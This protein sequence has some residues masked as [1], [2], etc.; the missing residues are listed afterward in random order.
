LVTN[1]RK[2]LFVTGTDTNVG[3]TIAS[4][5]LMH[6]Y[7][8]E[9]RLCYWKPIQTGIESDD[10]TA[11]VRMLGG[12][13]DCEML[14]RGIRLRLPLSP[15]LSARLAG[16]HINLDELVALL[17]EIPEST[18]PVVEGAGGILVPLNDHDLMVDLIARLDL[19]AVIVARS[20]LGTINHT[21]LSLESLR[22]GEIKIGGVIMIGEPNAENRAAIER[23]GKVPVLGELPVLDLLNPETLSQWAANELDPDGLLMEYLV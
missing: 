7:R 20:G 9:V 18:T 3:K 12:C 23:F 21:L 11:T 22:R 4:A 13:R 17:G 15:H 2:G 16:V 6:R 5:A 8:P 1:T 14:D 10:D 19:A